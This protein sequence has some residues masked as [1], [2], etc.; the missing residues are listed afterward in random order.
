LAQQ[1]FL[2]TLAELI[3]LVAILAELI[4][5]IGVYLTESI[6]VIDQKGYRNQKNQ[7]KVI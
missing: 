6:I 4:A 5:R 2:L 3:L 1:P 7:S